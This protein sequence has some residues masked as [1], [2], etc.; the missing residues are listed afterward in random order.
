MTF[1]RGLLLLLTVLGVVGFGWATADG[2]GKLSE[3]PSAPTSMTVDEIV[4]ARE[5]PRWVEVAG[6]VP[7]CDLVQ[8]AN[9][10]DVVPVIDPAVFD[11]ASSTPAVLLIALENDELCATLSTPVRVKAL[12]RSEYARAV[13]D[14]VKLEG[15]VVAANDVF[16]LEPDAPGTARENVVIPAGF[17]VACMLGLWWQLRGLKKARDLRLGAVGDVGAAPAGGV[18]AALA[19]GTA[20]SGAESIFPSSSMMLSAA[21]E[22]Q[23]FRARHVT[24][25]FLVVIALGFSA[26]GGVGALGVVNDLRA[27]YGGVDV[28]AEAKGSTSSK[29]V[30]SVL[31]IQLAW[32]MPGEARVRSANR[33]FMTLWTPDEHLGAVRALADDAE[34]V[35]FEE[36]VD[37]VPLRLPLILGAFG[38]AWGVFVGARTTRR[39]ADRIRQVGAN[40]VEGVLREVTVVENR[41]NGAVTGYTLGG[42]LDGRA[43]STQLGVDPGPGG[44]IVA[45]ADGGVLVA[46]SADGASFAPVFVT[47]EPFAWRAADWARAQAV[48]AARGSPTRLLER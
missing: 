38:L 39:N 26:L 15:A 40:V 7:R 6:G 29:I 36:A 34:V 16:E 14:D 32:Q 28:P 24:P 1:S 31:D 10:H 45:G 21:T 42:V 4:A 25:V 35:T 47:G 9:K 22:S 5:L 41:V 13:L 30:L 44:L 46:K 43:V 20:V 3:V 12:H 27:W 19:S 11:G 2:L 8:R 18:H 37:L 17:M 33:M 23:V 48:L